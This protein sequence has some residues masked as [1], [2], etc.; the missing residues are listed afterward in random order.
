MIQV[1]NNLSR[2]FSKFFWASVSEIQVLKNVV[3]Q[4]NS[5][6]NTANFFSPELTVT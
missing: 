6:K 2:T 5:Y 1:S 3:E 4:I